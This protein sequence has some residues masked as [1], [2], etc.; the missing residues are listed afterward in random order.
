MANSSAS[1]SLP[2]LGCD[3]ERGGKWS[4][5]PLWIRVRR[6]GKSAVAASLCRRTPHCPISEVKR[7]KRI[8]IMN[9]SIKRIPSVLLLLALSLI[10]R[11]QTVTE[12]KTLT[13]EG[14]KKVIA[15]AVVYAPSIVRVFFS[16]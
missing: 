12:K 16:V 15:A 6:V 7:Q 10:V 9:R 3:L 13:I 11:G 5:T 2:N 8:V 14:A 4:A 1:R